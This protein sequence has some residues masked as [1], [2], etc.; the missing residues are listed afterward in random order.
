[1]NRQARVAEFAG[2]DLTGLT[3]LLRNRAQGR[4]VRYVLSAGTPADASRP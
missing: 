4:A 2:R 3:E 1:M